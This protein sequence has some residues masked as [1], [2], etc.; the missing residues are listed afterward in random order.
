M[1]KI[2]LGVVPVVIERLLRL[3]K[4][5]VE[6]ICGMTNRMGKFLERECLKR[7]KWYRA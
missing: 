3:L 5:S 7:K 1:S 4:V 6:C 2:W